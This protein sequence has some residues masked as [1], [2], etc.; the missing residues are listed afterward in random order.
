MALCAEREHTSMGLG[1]SSF[2]V[3]RCFLE[4]PPPEVLLVSAARYASLMT[5]LTRGL[6]L[7][8]FQPFRFARGTTSKDELA[9]M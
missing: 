4:G 7:V 8:A 5:L 2:A 1:R 6:R 9:Q 3:A